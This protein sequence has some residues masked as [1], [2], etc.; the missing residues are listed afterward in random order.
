MTKAPQT[1]VPEVLAAPPED[2][3]EGPDPLA[4]LLRKG[5]KAA[6]PGFALSLVIHVAVLAVLGFI[7]MKRERQKEFPTVL[8]GFNFNDVGPQGRRKTITPVEVESVKI[9]PADAATGPRK[10]W[11]CTLG[12]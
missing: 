4:E 5:A 1:H 11:F 2:E 6:G 12:K 9:E 7:V 3:N 8:S 10:T